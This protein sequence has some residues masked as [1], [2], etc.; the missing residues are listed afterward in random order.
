MRLSYCYFH[1]IKCVKNA[2]IVNWEFFYG[3][4]WN[5][6]IFGSQPPKHRL[7]RLND[8]SQ[9]IGRLTSKA[10]DI[11]AE[12]RLPKKILFLLLEPMTLLIAIAPATKF[13]FK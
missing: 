12:M 10:F 2:L 8:I 11:N 4:M 7:V 3:K 1:L 6:I 5:K 9:Q 13:E